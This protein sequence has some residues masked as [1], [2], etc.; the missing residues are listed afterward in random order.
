MWHRAKLYFTCVSNTCYR[1]TVPNMNKINQF[2]YEISQQIHKMVEK[3]VCITKIWN[4]VKCSFTSMSNTWY[5]ITAP[6]MNK[7]TTFFFEISQQTLKIYEKNRHNYSNFA[8]RQFLFYN[9][10]AADGT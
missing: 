4:R 2:V 3:V 10:A 8:Q 6:N 1:I 7:I 9:A 5:L